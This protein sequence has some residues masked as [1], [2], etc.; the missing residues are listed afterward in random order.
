MFDYFN[1][2]RGDEF[3]K[4]HA[5]VHGGVHREKIGGHD[6]DGNSADVGTGSTAVPTPMASWEQ[7]ATRTR[8]RL[9]WCM[10][11]SVPMAG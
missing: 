5:L 7:Q 9:A 3:P 2:T 1:L 4:V 6:G 10:E 8:N 11:V